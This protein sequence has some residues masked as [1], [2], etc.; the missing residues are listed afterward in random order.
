MLQKIREKTYVNDNKFLEDIS[1]KTINFDEYN[2]DLKNLSLY[3][4]YTSIIN[5]NKNNIQENYSIFTT[6]FQI[7]QLAKCT[8]ILIDGKFKSC[9]RSYYQI[10]NISGYMPDINGLISNIYGSYDR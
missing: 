5:P 10:L 8:Q 6:K 1:K 7:N 2:P 9:P 4:K 3:H